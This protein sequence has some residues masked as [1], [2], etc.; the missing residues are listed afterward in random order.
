MLSFVSLN[1]LIWGLHGRISSVLKANLPGQTGK[2]CCGNKSL[3]S[4]PSSFAVCSKVRFANFPRTF[5]NAGGAEIAVDQIRTFGK[6]MATDMGE[7]YG[8][9]RV[10]PEG[11]SCLLWFKVS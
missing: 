1:T 4:L 10:T 7:G 9:V 2:R 8:V 3:L 6:R 11:I 5:I